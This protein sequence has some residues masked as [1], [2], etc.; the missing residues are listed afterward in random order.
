LRNV[1]EV[2]EVV[3]KYYLANRIPAKTQYFVREIS[4]EL[5]R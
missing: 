1:E 4:D 3:A 5:F 2:L